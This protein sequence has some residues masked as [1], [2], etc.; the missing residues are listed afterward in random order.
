M[1]NSLV[2]SIDARISEGKKK[3][4]KLSIVCAVDSACYLLSP[5]N[6]EELL[7]KAMVAFAEIGCDD[8]IFLCVDKVRHSTKDAILLRVIK[9]LINLK[10]LEMAKT[11][12]EEMRQGSYR[13]DA[14]SLLVTT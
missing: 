6:C 11:L 12:C 2:E 14:I 3:R 5:D 8:R 7:V 4:D 13:A 10:K 1:S 9:Q